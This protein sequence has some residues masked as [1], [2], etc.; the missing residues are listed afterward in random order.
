[1][2]M[3]ISKIK[4]LISYYKPAFL[5]NNKILTPVHAGRKIA[6][7]IN[8]DGSY[9]SEDEIEFLGN[10]MIGDDTGK[11]ISNKGRLYNELSTQYWAQYN[12]EKI[13]SPDYIGFMH[14]RRHFIFKDVSDVKKV[15]E[16]YYFEKIDDSYI[17]SIGLDEENI[18][19]V[20]N[21]NDILVFKPIQLNETVADQIKPYASSNLYDEKEIYLPL[22]K[23]TKKII[24]DKYPDF[25]TDYENYFSGY[26]H[27]FCNMFIMRKEIFLNYSDWLFSILE[28]LEKEPCIQ[29]LSVY[30]SR[31]IGHIGERL[32]GVYMTHVQ[33]QYDYSIKELDVSLVGNTEI[34]V[35]EANSKKAVC[36]GASDS[37]AKYTSVCID[38]IIENS[39]GKTNFDIIVLTSNMSKNNKTLLIENAEKK[40]I[41]IVVKNVNGKIRTLLK[42]H[43]YIMNGMFGHVQVET[44][45]RLTINST[46]SEYDDVIYI[47]AD[48]VVNDDINKLF[49]IP[50][51]SHEYAMAVPDIEARRTANID[52]D[53]KNYLEHTLNLDHYDDYFQAGLV[54]LDIKK[55]NADCPDIFI[56]SMQ[57]LSK[58]KIYFADQCI[59]NHAL[60]WKVKYLPIAWNVEWHIPMISPNFMAEL[61]LNTAQSYQD[62]RNNPSMIH[63]C[64]HIKPWFSPEKALANYF[65]RYAMRSPFYH[66]ML[67]NIKQQD[68]NQELAKDSSVSVKKLMLQRLFTKSFPLGTRRYNLSKSFLYSLFGGNERFITKMKSIYFYSA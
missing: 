55:I 20:V 22:F 13:D 38:S 58:E 37:Y 60:K 28:E 25:V 19:R 33:R 11:N 5:L 56:N 12:L 23:K 66:E 40:G 45:C 3:K 68:T 35:S 51:E 62:A 34:E 49:N 64:W 17:N 9:L 53:F 30:K 50:F 21:G 15:N 57:A 59:M 46:L 42:M 65:W 27:Y 61:P 41:N 2:S 47:D 10:S 16:L 54:R 67:A 7:Y 36:L 31:T 52:Q 14:H 32:L 44:L 1:M 8:K 48:T 26:K 18:Q 24:S 29:Q 63:Y 39:G 43:E 6:N 4:L